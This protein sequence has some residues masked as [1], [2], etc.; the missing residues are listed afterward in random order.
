MNVGRESQSL[1]APEGTSDRVREI[2]AHI[3]NLLARLYPMV[4]REDIRQ[5]AW[6]AY[7]GSAFYEDGVEDRDEEPDYRSLRRQ[8]RGPTERFCRQEKA[9]RAGYETHDEA[10]YS[11]PALRVLLEAWYAHGPQENPPRSYDDSV[12]RTGGNGAE[13]G[14]Y[15]VS[16]IDVGEALKGLKGPQQEILYYAYSPHYAGRTDWEIAAELRAKGWKEMTE[17]SFH[18]KVRWALN[19][20]QRQLGGRRL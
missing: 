11:L 10:Y 12:N 6:A 7:Y 9:A 1:T 17:D 15:L 14:D 5:E 2:H 16:L 19:R 8:M 4:P 3:S 20:L 18:G 13:Y